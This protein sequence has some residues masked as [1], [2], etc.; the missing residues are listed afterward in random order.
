M[1]SRFA[2][3][4]VLPGLRLVKDLGVARDLVA[5]IGH[6]IRGLSSYFTVYCMSWAA[7]RTIADCGSGYFSRLQSLSLDFFHTARTAT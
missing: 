6:L 4:L 7:A 2:G 5:A 1:D 3:E